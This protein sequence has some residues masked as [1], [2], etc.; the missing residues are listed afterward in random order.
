MIFGKSGEDTAV[1]TVSVL[2]NI[3][4]R[5][6]TL[7]AAGTAGVKSWAEVSANYTFNSQDDYES[8]NLSSYSWKEY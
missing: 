3:I 1:L 7:S 4:L 8:Y 2:G 5:K 6:A